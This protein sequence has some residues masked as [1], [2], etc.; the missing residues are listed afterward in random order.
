M[1]LVSR[2]EEK[3]IRAAIKEEANQKCTD[4]KAEYCKCLAGAKP[5]NVFKCK[6]ELN[7]WNGC[8]KRINSEEEFENRVKQLMKDKQQAYQNKSKPN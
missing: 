6:N 8:V 5:W 7:A 4:E 1:E 3:E 2:N